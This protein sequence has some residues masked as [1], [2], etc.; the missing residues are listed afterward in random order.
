[1]VAIA[2]TMSHSWESFTRINMHLKIKLRIT[3]VILKATLN[4]GRPKHALKEVTFFA[5]NFC[6]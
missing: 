3:T 2:T 5:K 1:M 4:Y 6:L